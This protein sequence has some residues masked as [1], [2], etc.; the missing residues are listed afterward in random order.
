MAKAKPVP[1]PD[2]LSILDRVLDTGGAVNLELARHILNLKLPDRDVERMHELAARNGEG[3]I[4]KAELDEYD[5][6]LQVCGLLSILHS[7]ARMALNIK[8]G[9]RVTRE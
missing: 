4:S 9:R 2:Q 7:K 1:P 3:G 8:P 5:E 6:Y